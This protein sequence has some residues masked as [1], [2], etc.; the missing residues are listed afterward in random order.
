MIAGQR[1]ELE[2]LGLS[3]KIGIILGKLLR[4]TF[5]DSLAEPTVF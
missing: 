4:E 1:I 5:S 2:G 3:K